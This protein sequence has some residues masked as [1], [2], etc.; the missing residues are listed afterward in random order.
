[1]FA[2]CVFRWIVFVCVMRVVGVLWLLYCVCCCVA[3]VCLQCVCL[4]CVLFKRI[5]V[6]MSCVCCIVFFVLGCLK[7]VFLCC[8]V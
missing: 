6:V 2:L 8:C 7:C 3:Y 5:V 4:H 1:M